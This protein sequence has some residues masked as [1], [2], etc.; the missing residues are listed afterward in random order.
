VSLESPA[1]LIEVF[2]VFLSLATDLHIQKPII[3]TNLK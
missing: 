2:I 1:I 3:K